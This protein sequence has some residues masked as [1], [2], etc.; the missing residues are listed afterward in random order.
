MISLLN[1]FLRLDW[2]T[3]ITAVDALKHPYFT[4][5]PLPA[6]P[7]ELP[8]F[9]DSHELDR[10]H[11]RQKAKPAAPGNNAMAVESERSNNSGARGATG[12]G[13]RVPGIPRGSGA[14]SRNDSG[15]FRRPIDVRPAAILSWPE[16]FCY[17]PL[18][19][20]LLLMPMLFSRF[21]GWTT[22]KALTHVIT[23]GMVKS[24]K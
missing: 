9:E 6:R 24:Q 11:F 19:K 10:R 12:Q 5:P 16:I 2:R 15:N 18:R 14:P 23:A 4:S 13:S 22:A 7:G 3:R 17:I 1:E 8:Q 21:T 20:L